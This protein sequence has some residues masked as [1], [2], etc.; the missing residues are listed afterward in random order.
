MKLS[1]H[2]TC[3]AALASACGAAFANGG[4]ISIPKPTDRYEYIYVN[5]KTGLPMGARIYQCNGLIV[6]WGSLVGEL[7]VKKTPCP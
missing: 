1:S 2:L 4:T 5:K 7:F 3:V 6:E